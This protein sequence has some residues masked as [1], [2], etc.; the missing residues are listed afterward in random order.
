MTKK[1]A[2]ID[3]ISKNHTNA[4]AAVDF[5]IDYMK[6]ALSAKRYSYKGKNNQ[7]RYDEMRRNILYCI[8][9]TSIQNT[10]ILLNRNYKPLGS[11]SKD[12]IIYEQFKNLHIELTDIQ[13]ETVS[14]KNAFR[15]LFQ[16]YNPPWSNRYNAKEYLNRLIEFR[17]LL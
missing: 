3:D 2:V 13:I 12:W 6:T 15:C 17:K 7:P 4:A 10:Q 1:D 11:N 9:Y 8:H 14:E 16:D 5:A